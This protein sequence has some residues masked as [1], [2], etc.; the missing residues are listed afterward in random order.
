[1]LRR[2]TGQFLNTR[3]ELVESW[4]SDTPLDRL[5]RPDEL[6]GVVTWL[7]SD[8]SSYCTGS[9]YVIRFL[10]SCAVLKLTWDVV[11]L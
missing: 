4:C 11:L 6:R 3:P 5:A 7:A 10:L 1:M 8:A 2:M 9:E